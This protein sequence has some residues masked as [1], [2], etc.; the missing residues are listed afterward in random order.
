MGTDPSSAHIRRHRR[1]SSFIREVRRTSR[2]SVMPCGAPSSMMAARSAAPDIIIMF[3]RRGWAAKRAM[4]LPAS[5][6]RPSS[7]NAP[8]IRRSDTAFAHALSG[9]GVSHGRPS[10]LTVPQSAAD[11][12][13]DARSASRISGFIAGGRDAFSRSVQSRQHTPGRTRPARPLRCSARSCVRGR[14]SRRLIPLDG[15]N[16][17][18]RIRPESTTTVTPGIVRDVSA[19][20]VARMMRRLP[21][22]GGETARSCSSF[23]SA[24]YSGNTSGKPFSSS[25]HRLIS[26]S[27]GRKHRI[28]PSSVSESARRTAP[29]ACA[30]IGAADGT[31]R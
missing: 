28:S 5:V 13:V 25:A 21:G 1:A 20:E 29:A 14:V 15:E 17:L 18:T 22:C 26:P 9:G 23:E 24:P 7:S 12:T 30:H 31:C 6:M 19:I 11:R 3:A 16:L 8:S 2:T 4:R 27:P 10:I